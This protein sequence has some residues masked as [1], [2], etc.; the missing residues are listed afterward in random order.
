VSFGWIGYRIIKKKTSS[1]QNKEIYPEYVYKIN[2]DFISN[3][4]YNAYKG[5]LLSVG[6]DKTK[7]KEKSLHVLS[8]IIDELSYSEN[9]VLTYEKENELEEFIKISGITAEE[10]PQK[11]K[12]KVVK[13][14]LIRDLINGEKKERT[15]INIQNLPFSF[16]KKE[17]FIYV[18]FNVGLYEYKTKTEYQAGSRGVSLRIAKG[19]SYRIGAVRGE[20]ISNDVQEFIDYGTLAITSHNLYF[21]SQKNTFRVSH[22]KIFGIQASKESVIISRDGN[23]GKPVEFVVNDPVFLVNI[24]KHAK[25]WE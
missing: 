15:A 9:G 4:A 8:L 24:L 7:A 16:T 18:F 19:I 3:G 6:N 21:H 5:I 10:I 1:K 22:E 23:R 13:I 2:N 12:E 11:Q 17:T 25:N 14:L 20:R